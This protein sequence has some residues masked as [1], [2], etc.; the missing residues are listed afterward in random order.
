MTPEERLE[1][2]AKLKEQ[3]TS[4]FTSGS[5]TTAAELY[6]KAAELVDEDEDNEPLPDQE[7]DMFIKCWGNAAM[8]YVKTSSWP[9]VINCCNKVLNKCPEEAKSNIKVVYRRGLAKI[10]VGELK[11]AKTD[12]MAAYG[13]DNKNKDVRKAIADLKVRMADAKKKEK[14][15]FGGIFG[16]ASLYDEK[17]GPLI[18]NAK[19]T[20]PHVFFDVVQGDEKLGRIVMQLYEDITPKTAENFKKLCTGKAGVGKKGVPLHYKGSTFHRVIKVSICI[21]SFRFMSF[22]LVN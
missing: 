6:K 13:M 14:E 16:K 15:T 4:E 2:A 11:D 3:G 22:G 19:G 18:P 7:K 5:P 12:L 21:A 20:N 1:K 17:E 8:C 9:D 10:H